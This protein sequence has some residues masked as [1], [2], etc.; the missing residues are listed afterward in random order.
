[1]SLK[2]NSLALL[3]TDIADKIRQ[4]GGGTADIVA[5]DFPS[6]IESIAGG[7]W[8][9]S[10]E[11]VLATFARRQ[12]GG[13]GPATIEKIYGKTV[14]WNQLVKIASS[15][16]TN[17]GI[18]FTHVS[19]NIIKVQGTATAN[20]FLRISDNLTQGVAGH[21][22]LVYAPSRA[23]NNFYIQ[24]ASASIYAN[25]GTDIYTGANT[26]TDAIYIRCNS[27]VTI[28]W[29]GAVAIFDL[30]LMYGE[31]K[32]P[33]TVEEFLSM[34]PEAL[35][36][37]YD[38]GSLLPVKAES[39]I[40]QG[41]NQWD[42]EWEVGILDLTNGNII[43][44]AQLCSK[45][46]IP[47]EPGATYYAYFGVGGVGRLCFY[48]ENKNYLSYLI[49]V[50]GN[51]VL[52]SFPSNARYFR[53]STNAG[54]IVGTTYNHDICINI[55]DSSINGQ[56]FPHHNSD[57]G[58]PIL[59]H[60]PTGLRGV[61]DS[62]DEIGPKKKV[63]R[64]GVVDLGTLNWVD[65]ATNRFMVTNF[66]AKYL[67]QL[68]CP[69]LSSHSGTP[70]TMP[71]KSIAVTNSQSDPILRAKDSDYTTAAD[72]KAAMSGVELDYELAEPIE[73]DINEDMTYLPQLGGTEEVS[74]ISAEFKAEIR[75]ARKISE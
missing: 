53:F 19:G 20:V 47:I 8:L 64:R 52:P 55:S 11:T 35:T 9:P 42:E 1:M 33:S 17:N 25:A 41:V 2:H 6:A 7:E 58:L 16:A 44:G 39:I 73:T 75:Y 27:G 60:F 50:G 63:Q 4:V 22:Y 62:Y 54:Y 67:G 48:D 23:A 38:A 10:A 32:E 13:D 12:S 24:F 21:K 49:D 26:S 43:S 28:D 69:K 65:D 5:D 30:T 70:G 31:G 51:R 45:N 40:T 74:P 68:L 66:P 37:P 59:K 34:H 56:Y 71:D 14:V 46:Y 3:F 57:V 15:G 18:T 61:G 36:A 29:Q 72:F